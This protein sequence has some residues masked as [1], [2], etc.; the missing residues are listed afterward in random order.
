MLQICQCQPSE[1]FA[2]FSSKLDLGLRM[3]RGCLVYWF[4]KLRSGNTALSLVCLSFRCRSNGILFHSRYLCIH[5]SMNITCSKSQ[6]DVYCSIN[7]QHNPARNG[8]SLTGHCWIMQEHVLTTK[9]TPALQHQG[10]PDNFLLNIFQM[11][12]ANYFTPFRNK[13]PNVDL[14]TAIH[15]AVM[16]PIHAGGA[17]RGNRLAALVASSRG[18]GRGRGIHV[19]SPLAS[20]SS[21]RQ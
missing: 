7:A 2:K 21:I 9:E 15:K 4:N 5:L 6:Q 16:E 12:S 20:S 18:K 19:A 1:L 14:Q 10:N 3:S 11:Q 8:C 13:L 17:A